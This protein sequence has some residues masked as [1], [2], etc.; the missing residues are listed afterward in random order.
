MGALGHEHL[1]LPQAFTP[2]LLGEAA[3]GWAWSPG[4]A[5]T[6]RARLSD[7]RA[8]QLRELGLGAPAR[9]VDPRGGHRPDH[10]WGPGLNWKIKGKE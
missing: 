3:P 6:H 9:K 5:V 4:E 8:D 10:D 1:D 2:W 7:P